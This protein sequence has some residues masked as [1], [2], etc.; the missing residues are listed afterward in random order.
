[1]AKLPTILIAGGA[2]FIGSQV[3]KMLNKAGYKTLILDN[4]S[5][6]NALTVQSGELIKGDIGDKHLLSQIF[7]THSIEAVMHFAAFIDVGESV[8]EPSKYYF[9]NVVNTLTLLNTM[10]EHNIKKF[11]F[12]SSAAIYGYPT[13]DFIAENHP[14]HPI[15]PYGETKWMVEKILRDFDE[16]YQLKSCCLRYFNA[17]GGDPD[18]KI[19]NYQ[20]KALNLIPIALHSLKTNG[21]LTIY[22]TDYP[23][24]DGS[25][26]RDYI[27]IEDLGSAHIL[28]LEKLL[29]G[30]PSTQYNLGNGR[31]HSV[32]EVIQATEKVTGKKLNVIEGPRRPGDPPLL[33]ADASKAKNE[34][35]WSPQY[36]DLE[37][38]IAHAW[39]ALDK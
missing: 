32:K 8:R 17:A 30:G 28:G 31:G 5:Q 39:K 7:S 21:Q 19:K 18:G 26:I 3:N 27:H 29:S 1:M 38:M 14:C 37:I 15:N 12:S 24:T 36:P 22:G 33:L 23:T 9:N 16:A 20:K 10:I 6:G 4:L 13:Q 11:I 2:G 35:G 25:C 34:L